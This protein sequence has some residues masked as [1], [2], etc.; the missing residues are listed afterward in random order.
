MRAARTFI[1]VL[2]L[3]TALAPAPAG[4]QNAASLAPPP[5]GI[6]QLDSPPTATWRA[7]HADGR[8]DTRIELKQL[9]GGREEVFVAGSDLAEI[10]QVGRF[11]RPDVRK[12]VLRVDDQRLT[13]TVGA[14]SVVGA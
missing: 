6:T 1:A 9:L 14:R 2:I 7:L 13:F 4:A 12:L 5:A 10:L 8:V 11:W 3:T